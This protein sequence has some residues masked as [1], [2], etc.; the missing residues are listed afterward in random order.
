MSPLRIF[1]TRYSE[2]HSWSD[3]CGKLD[4]ETAV[5]RDHEARAV[6]AGAPA[7]TAPR[8]T[9]V[10]RKVRA[11]LTTRVPGSG[12]GTGA[13]GTPVDASTAATGANAAGSIERDPFVCRRG[14]R[15]S[16]KRAG[17][18]PRRLRRWWPA[19]SPGLSYPASTLPADSDPAGESLRENSAENRRN[20]RPVTKKRA[21]QRAD[22]ASSRPGG[23]QTPRMEVTNGGKKLRLASGA[24]ARRRSGGDSRHRRPPR[25]A[26]AQQKHHSACQGEGA[27]DRPPQPAP[28]SIGSE[29]TRS[30]SPRRDRAAASTCTTNVF[31]GPE[32]GRTASA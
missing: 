4:A 2:C 29:A 6:D 8:R 10:C 32:G 1:L 20:V 28:P 19:R 17:N 14:R 15:G 27:C 11:I 13:C 30:S 18:A 24:S 5:D 25:R 16:R 12:V 21:S 31:A 23:R 9:G 22:L 3:W 26:V 7:L